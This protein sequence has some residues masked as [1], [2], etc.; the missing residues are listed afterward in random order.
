[1]LPQCILCADL[2]KES[3]RS[4][5]GLCLLCAHRTTVSEYASGGQRRPLEKGVIDN[6]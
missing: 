3:P 5:N 1:M 2:L 4:G 6:A